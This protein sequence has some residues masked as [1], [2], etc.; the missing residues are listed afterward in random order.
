MLSDEVRGEG[1]QVCHRIGGRA[2]ALLDGL[3]VKGGGSPR[4]GHKTSII[5]GQSHMAGF[6]E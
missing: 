1:G 6:P 5:V 4:L 2:S 3:C